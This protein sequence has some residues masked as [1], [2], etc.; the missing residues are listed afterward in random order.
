MEPFVT[1]KLTGKC[2]ILHGKD[3][4]QEPDMNLGLTFLILNIY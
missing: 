2:C 3:A 4:L 1:R